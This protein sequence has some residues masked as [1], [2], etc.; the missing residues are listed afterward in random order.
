MEKLFK[1]IATVVIIF[2]A[3]SFALTNYVWLNSSSPASPYISWD[4]A[5]HNIQDAV[6][7]AEAGDMVL[8]TNGIYDTG[9]A[10][11]PSCS[12]SNRL[13]ITKNI[14]VKSV[15]GPKNTIILGKGPLGYRAIRCVYMTAGILSGFML[16]NGHTL[17]PGFSSSWGDECGGGAYM[18]N[19]SGLITNCVIIGNT[20]NEYGGGVYY[21]RVINCIISSNW[22]YNGGG[23]AFSTVDNC[24]FTRNAGH[25]GGA[26]FYGI[27][28]NSVITGNN[29]CN[30]A[31]F[32]SSKIFN[33]IISGNTALI[34]G[35]AAYKSTINR[36]IISENA[37]QYGGGVTDGKVYNCEIT[38]N[39]GWEGGGT[40]GGR[41]NNTKIVGNYAYLAGG[42]CY[43]T[44]NNCL[45]SQNVSTN[46]GGGTCYGSLNN[47]T[48]TGNSAKFGGGTYD[49]VVRNSIIYY[50]YATSCENHNFSDIKCSCTFPK[51]DG[52]SNI[53][54]DPILLD[55]GHIKFNS[56]CV[57][58]GCSN[59]VSGVDIDNDPW[60]S[61]PAM[62]CDQPD[63]SCCTGSLTVTLSA[64]Y[65]K[66][67]VG[68]KNY[69]YGSVIGRAVSNVLSFSDGTI[70]KNTLGGYYSWDSTG[71]YKVILSAFNETYSAGIASTVV[72]EVLEEHIYYVDKNNTNSVYPYISLETAATNIQDAINI[73]IPGE[74]VLVNDGVYDSGYSIHLSC[75][76]RIIIDKDITVKSING[77]DKT[78][79]FGNGPAGDDA[80]RGV[81]LLSGLIEGFTITNGH[82]IALGSEK[83]D[84]S[85][86]GVNSY[87]GNGIISNCVI[88]GNLARADGGGVAYCT[89]F[90]SIIIGNSAA[91]Y[92]GGAVDSS[93]EGCIIENNLAY[94]G[95]GVKG[96]SIKK[97]TIVRNTCKGCGGGVRSGKAYDCMIIANN[98]KVNG[99]GI[100]W[101]T[102]VNCNFISNIAKIGGGAYESVVSMSAISNNIAEIGGGVY[103]GTI[104]N[105]IIAGN[106]AA[107]NGGGFCGYYPFKMTNCL[108]YGMNT[109]L[110]GGGGCLHNSGTVCDCI[111]AGNYA[112]EY[113]GGV[114]CTNG[115]IVIN[116]IIYNNHALLGND[117]WLHYGT[118]SEF[119]YCCTTPTNDLPNEIN[120]IPDDPLFVDPAGNDYH[121]QEGSPCINAGTNA[122]AL[123]PYDL[124][125]N[126]RIYDGTVDMG[127][128]EDVPE[129]WGICILGLLVLFIK[130]GVR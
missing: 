22:A 72:V 56:I 12:C 28:S 99:G 74:T 129:P 35:G 33:C 126:P 27:I 89:V 79:I 96:G 16:T 108:I 8:V 24:L 63:N 6:E 66:I 102:A 92:G 88:C 75:R 104:L 46:Q 3:N 68:Y 52:T 5:A 2:C 18:E 55:S 80:V 50:N 109:A 65:N 76:N 90:D 26:A 119:I 101:G 25:G 53:S 103:N 91:T 130:G 10:M 121:L 54:Q 125:G 14:T 31:G 105:C 73:A 67:S 51:V 13:I 70:W 58:A 112:Y 62:G 11:T 115:G 4:T 40:Y 47:C 48:I 97:S 20:A 100:L 98:A 37:A 106:F 64:K 23:T 95:G 124:D 86:G 19:G 49:S 71:T 60:D 82:T 36:C 87:S 93:I 69:F 61:P 110:Y 118:Y 1:T 114:V 84:C 42:T 120:C 127:C 7:A 122:Y 44:V 77:R 78:V 116:S 29:A 34:Y 30:G 57:G 85:G 123:M 128:Y 41:I 15:N 113:G 117:N 94:N 9:E 38:K 17:T 45:I 81:L 107:I 83:Y 59:F 32:E 43:G 111:I 21:G 39:F